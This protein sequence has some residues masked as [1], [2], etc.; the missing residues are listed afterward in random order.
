MLAVLLLGGAIAAAI[1]L[2]GDDAPPATT[3][4]AVPVVAGQTLDAA[5]AAIEGAG[6][7]VGEVTTAASTTVAEGTVIEST[8]S[9]G[10]KVDEGSEVAL[11]VSGGP[12]TIAVPNVVGLSE[13]RARSTLEDAGFTSVNSRQTDSLEDEGNVVAVD[14]GEGEQAAPN[15]PITLQVSTG[16]IK[17]PDVTGK[18]EAEARSI[19]TDAGFSAGQ[20]GTEE[21]ES[22]DGARGRRR[23]H[24][25]AGRQRRRAPARTSRC[26]SPRPPRRSLSRTSTGRRDQ[27]R[28]T[29]QNAASPTSAASTPRATANPRHAWHDPRG[30]RGAPTTRSSCW[31]SAAATAGLRPLAADSLR[32][33]AVAASTT[34]GSGARPHDV[35]QV[36]SSWCPPSVSTDSGWNCTPSMGSSRCR[37]AMT[38][39][40]AVCP[41]TSSSAGT[42]AGSTASEW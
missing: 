25:P 33:A 37:S 22:D 36:A 10:A 31:S 34:S 39:P 38:M 2:S 4:V 21:V 7:K 8:P 42:V 20:I 23:R 13:D 32:A 28:Q 12:D 35:S 30:L 40:E 17:V 41:V 5:R 19:L 3:Q 24:R 9:A 6:L 11:S 15:T 16:T 18:S 1:A 26:R 29:L 27:A 14:P